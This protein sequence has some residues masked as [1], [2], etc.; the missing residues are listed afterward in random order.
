VIDRSTVR[1]ALRT[2]ARHRGF[3][4][5]A[6]LS[7]SIAV[8]LN[9]TMYSALDKLIDPQINARNPERVYS[10]RF[11]AGPAGRQLHPSVIQDALRDGI[12]GLEGASGMDNGRFSGAGA[13]VMN[14]GLLAEAGGRYTRAEAVDVQPNFFEF[15][16]TQPIAGRV[17]SAG[18]EG[19]GA[20][21]ISDRLATK[22]F[23]GESP[24]GQALVLH[25]EA[26]GVIG[27]V[28]RTQIFAPLSYDLWALRRTGMRPVPVSMLRFREELEPYGLRAQL[29]VVA[30]RLEMSVGDPPGTT[31]FGGGAFATA[32]RRL[33]VFDMSIIG[34]VLAVLL[35]ACANLR[36][37]SSLPPGWCSASYSRF[38]AFTWFA[39][40]SRRQ[41]TRTRSSRRRA[42]ACLHSRPAPPSYACSSSGCFL[43]FASRASIPARCSRAE[44]ERARIAITAAATVCS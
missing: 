43:R 37:A 44:R 5:V 35:V 31:A 26:Y 22:L 24:I 17:F 39:R 15:L 36:R 11:F 14:P 1:I 19:T 6:V 41:W 20:V 8:A 30:R 27:V 23:A 25:G 38:G 32:K 28:R 10:F 16:G 2:L 7:I 12:P 40:R 29:H 34:A 21:V 33:T 4:T 42:G 13:G 9:T 18:D 3:T